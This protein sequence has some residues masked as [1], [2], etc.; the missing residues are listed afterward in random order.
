MSGSLPSLSSAVA[1]NYL[2]R[3]VLGIAA[4]PDSASSSVEPGV[5]GHRVFGLLWRRFLGQVPSASSWIDWH[6]RDLLAT[7]PRVARATQHARRDWI[8]IAA[9]SPRA[10]ALPKRPASPNSNV[11]AGNGFRAVSAACIRRHT[12]A[13]HASAV[14]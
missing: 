1:I 10:S 9:A 11:V 13:E 14:S 8:W 5:D 3:A 2:D 7:L 6:A 4:P 12:A